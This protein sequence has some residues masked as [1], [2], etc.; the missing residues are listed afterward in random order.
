MPIFWPRSLDITFARL[1]R[2][3]L[4]VVA[5][6]M[7]RSSRGKVSEGRDGE[8][9]ARRSDYPFTLPIQV[10]NAVRKL[11]R[12]VAVSGFTK[13]PLPSSRVWTGAM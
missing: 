8:G 12:K 6:R 11:F 5:K 9:V 3:I 2:A 13:P 1:D 7:P 10:S 4:L